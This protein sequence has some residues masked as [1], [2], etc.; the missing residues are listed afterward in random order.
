MLLFYLWVCTAVYILYNT[1]KKIYVAFSRVLIA[2]RNGCKVPARIS[3]ADPLLGSDHVW[4]GY[5][6][7]SEHTYLEESR[8]YF[9]RYGNTYQSTMMAATVINTIEPENIKAILSTQFKNFG[10]GAR[11]RNAFQPVLGYGIFATD[12]QQWR[13]SRNMIR[14]HFAQDQLANLEILERHTQHL[15]S[16]LPQ[17]GS[18]V[19]LQKLFLRLTM[20]T[21]TEIFFGESSSTLLQTETDSIQ[22]F[23]GA[24]SRA[25]K[26]MV[27]DYALGMLSKLRPHSDYNR[28]VEL[29]KDY[30][31]PY[32]EAAIHLD[33]MNQQQDDNSKV[34]QERYILLR[35][36]VREGAYHVSDLTHE[37]LNLVVAGRD[38]TASLLSSFWFVV[39]RRPDVWDQ[40]RQEVSAL[41]GDQPERSQL[42]TMQY[43]RACLNESK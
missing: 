31:R 6:H 5:Q 26:M 35:E 33:S 13:N 24:F 25:Q 15:I 23:S 37:L 43:L 4:K 3:H 32:V 27:E 14:P 10:L 11:R 12:G 16:A 19:D 41:E 30:I 8:K 1:L 22:G 28:D 40:L 42:K 17:K 20:D 7:L 21:A 38:T 9:L 39:A 18:T 34:K 29:L 36:L 2:R